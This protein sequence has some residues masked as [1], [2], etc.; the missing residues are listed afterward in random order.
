MQKQAYRDYASFQDDP[1]LEL[2]IQTSKG[3][4][5]GPR[6][7]VQAPF[8]T[9]LHA[10]LEENKFEDI[11]SWQPH[12]RC[13]LLHKPKE[14]VRIVMPKYFKQSKITSFQRQL[15]LYGFTR[16]LSAGPDKGGYYHELFL[17]GN[18]SKLCSSIMRMKV[19]GT[20]CRRG[21]SDLESEPNFYSME[22]S[23]PQSRCFIPLMRKN[24]GR[25]T[26]TAPAAVLSYVSSTDSSAASHCSS[27]EESTILD[28]NIPDAL[29]FLSGIPTS[30]SCSLAFCPH[31]YRSNYSNYSRYDALDLLDKDTF[32]PSLLKADISMHEDEL[33][34]AVRCDPTPWNTD[35]DLLSV[36]D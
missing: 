33:M 19:K 29:S 34:V 12:G 2:N 5:K 30:V 4:R 27:S 25:Q 35:F 6:G 13:F 31:L 1:I 7:G 17:R 14:F 26:R 22:S 20:K 32:S 11:I 10:L 21:A 28:E 36:F 9:K 24:K 15:N 8:P 23:I 3:R 18:Y 16:I